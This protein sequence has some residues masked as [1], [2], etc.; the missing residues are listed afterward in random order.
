MQCAVCRADADD[1][2]TRCEITAYCSRD[3][4]AKHW[5]EHRSGCAIG[6]DLTE[7]LPANVRVFQEVMQEYLDQIAPLER[8]DDLQQLFKI[9]HTQGP[10]TEQLA[11]LLRKDWAETTRDMLNKTYLESVLKKAAEWSNTYGKDRVLLFA[12]TANMRKRRPTRGTPPTGWRIGAFAIVFI[13]EEGESALLSVL[14]SR[15]FRTRAERFSLGGMMHY[16]MFARLRDLGVKHLYLE[17]ANRDF[18]TSGGSFSD[19][20]NDLVQ[21]YF[22]LLYRISATDCANP[23]LDWRSRF[24]G[25]TDSPR[26]PEQS[27]RDRSSARYFVMQT[28]GTNG[29]AMSWCDLDTQRIVQ[30]AR[31]AVGRVV[32][33]LNSAATNNR[34]D[35][36]FLVDN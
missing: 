16:M 22:R 5:A 6:D 11:E 2:C 33:Q 17:A 3:C 18:S 36:F 13:D 35:D 20:N 9:F 25:L 14:G 30:G 28:S 1:L 23:D 8:T 26:R 10:I 34:I 19:I 15:D 32:D 24:H 12:I 29:L 7:G 21:I 31:D 27:S 4:Q